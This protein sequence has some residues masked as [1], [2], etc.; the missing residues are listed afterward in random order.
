[1][2]GIF[3]SYIHLFKDLGIGTY[4]ALRNGDTS[5]YKKLWKDYGKKGDIRH[6]NVLQGLYDLLLSTLFITLIRM[7]FFDDPE[8]TRISYK[9]QLQ[10]AGSM[11]QNL[12]WIAD[13]STQD[14]SVLRLLDQGLFTWE[15]PS[16]NI[17][18]TTA[19]N[20]LRAAGDD[21]LN[22]AEAA[23]SGTVN[24]VGMFKPLRPAV[25]KLT[26]ES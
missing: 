19:R 11:F 24:S 7:M 14:F 3:Q 9:K 4:E 20:F 6:S 26:E 25:R 12:Y 17:L 15:V 13:Q 22:I 5:V 23:L 16:F 10:N 21:D 8:V 1:M 2:E 18:Q